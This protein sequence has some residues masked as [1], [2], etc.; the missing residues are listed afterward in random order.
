MQQRPL[1]LISNPKTDF[2]L[3]PVRV[4]VLFSSRRDKMQ[5]FGLQKRFTFLVL[6]RKVTKEIKTLQVYRLA[7]IL[8]YSTIDS[9]NAFTRTSSCNTLVGVDK[10][11]SRITADEQQYQKMYGVSSYR[12]VR[13]YVPMILLFKKNGYAPAYPFF[14]KSLFAKVK[15]LPDHGGRA[16]LAVSFCLLFLWQKSTVSRRR[17]SKGRQ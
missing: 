11:T 6:T 13:F 2:S 8:K 5:A 12:T 15:S 7:K 4:G 10:R 14:H 16:L 3:P 9:P 17:R 1:I